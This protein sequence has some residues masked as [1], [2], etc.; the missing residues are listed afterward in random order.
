MARWAWLGAL[1]LLVGCGGG[2]S[3]DQAGSTATSATRS[4]S[5]AVG[6]STGGSTVSSSTTGGGGSVPD[7]LGSRR[8]VRAALEAVLASNDPADA[9]GSYVTEHYLKVAYGGRQSCVQAQAPGSAAAALRSFRIEQEATQAT[10]VVAS[11]IPR[12]G[13]YD[14]S[15][16]RADLVFASDHYR[17]NALRANVPVG[18]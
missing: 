9:C 5:P 4:N 6:S 8:A 1:L 7:A 17:V 12:G 13:P 18:P 15:R 11:A 3:G 10:L 14:G 16:V 2:G